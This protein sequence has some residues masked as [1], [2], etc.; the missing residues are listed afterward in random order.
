MKDPVVPR[1]EATPV[2]LPA[3]R[4]KTR[5]LVIAGPTASGKSALAL[6]VAERFDGV[7]INADSMQLYRELK[8][9]TAQPDEKALAR[10][11]HRLYG[12]L[13]SHEACS[14]GRWRAIALKEIEAAV[15]AGMLPI[16]VGG[17]GLYIKVLIEG[18]APIP[19]IPEK[20]RA[21]A[22]KLHARLGG[23]A[24][25]E[26]LAR[27]DPE[28][29][30][31]LEPG[32]SQRLVR[33]WEVLEATGRSL[34]SWQRAQGPGGPPGLEFKTLLFDPPRSELYG[35]CDARFARM[36]ENGA[37][38]EVAAL[39]RLKLDPRLPAM[40][41]VGVKELLGF[42]HGE[43]ELEEARERA[44]RATRNYAK[45]QVTWFRRQMRANRVVRA[46]YSESFSEEIFSFIL[47]LSLTRDR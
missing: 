27:R 26:A 22:R 19:E 37:L 31:R 14:A 3:G 23:A 16:L 18:L 41:A 34:A 2:R 30:R 10:V 17:T 1:G 38:D 28:T 6:A 42:L 39:D 15:R 46:Q 36:I 43:L 44:Q 33:A 12:I 20:V 32:D 4:A 40:K 7:V 24:F 35:A 47:K 25:H 8:V 45:R 9:L 5:A 11:P 29:A 21:A 13:G